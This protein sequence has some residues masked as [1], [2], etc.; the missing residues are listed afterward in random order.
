MP[1]A[2]FR[3]LYAGNLFYLKGMHLGMRALA[4]ARVRGADV[5]LR[6]VGDGPARRD[7][8]KLAR[9]LGVAAHVT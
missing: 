1:G 6:V 5:T 8:E 9:E 7:L 3:L 2:P 4:S